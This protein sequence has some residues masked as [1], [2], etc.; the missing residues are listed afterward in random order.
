MESFGAEKK[1]KRE[2]W[3]GEGWN[4]VE[5]DGRFDGNEKSGRGSKRKERKEIGV[6]TERRKCKG[7]LHK[8]TKGQVKEK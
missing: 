7:K 6:K 2:E 3:E 8:A 5:K 1:A 4:G